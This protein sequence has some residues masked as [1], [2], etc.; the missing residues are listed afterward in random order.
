[1]TALD[2]LG[3]KLGDGAFEIIRLNRGERTNKHPFHLTGHAMVVPT[4]FVTTMYDLGGIRQD[5]TFPSRGRD[6]LLYERG[7]YTPREKYE[8]HY[9]GLL[10]ANLREDVPLSIVTST[11]SFAFF[12]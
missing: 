7:W 2:V 10:P 3:G 1:M 8:Q 9:H 11:W 5:L 4:V 12:T 6:T